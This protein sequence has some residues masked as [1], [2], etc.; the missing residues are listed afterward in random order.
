M[1][2][3]HYAFAKF[4]DLRSRLAQ[5]KGKLFVMD[6]KPELLSNLEG[7]LAIQLDK[8][9]LKG[10]WT[11][12]RSISLFISPIPLDIAKIY[13]DQH[14]LWQSGLEIYQYEVG[15]DNLPPGIG[16]RLVE[17]PEKTKLLYEKQDWEKANED[18]TL[19]PKYL[20]EIQDK[21]KSCG[22]I[23]YG[24]EKLLKVSEPFRKHTRRYME[25]AADI[26]LEYPEDGGFKK[27]AAC[28]PHVMIYP[29]HKP[30]E[31]SDVKL[32][33]LK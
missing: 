4:D 11:Y 15:I 7:S 19:I 8:I 16:F 28:V 18:K 3:Y 17:S 31:Y 9:R 1:K 32:I 27:Y 14:E 2:F 24:R 20:K 5:G 6:R 26:A 23:G 25:K 21:E 13:K 30:I 29:G 10:D 12:D 22:Y 33:T